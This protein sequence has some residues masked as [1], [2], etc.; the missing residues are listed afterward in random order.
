MRVFFVCS[1]V[2]ETTLLLYGMTESGDIEA[3]RH[4][5]DRI[6]HKCVRGRYT[7]YVLRFTVNSGQCE[8]GGHVNRKNVLGS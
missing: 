3:V 8:H 6:W 5:N 2:T 7:Q 1:R 4:M